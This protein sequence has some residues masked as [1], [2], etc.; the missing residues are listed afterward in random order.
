[1]LLG[2][3]FIMT[4]CL[5]AG[6]QPDAGDPG[7]RRLDQLAADRVFASLPAGAVAAGPLAEI[8][9]RYRTPAFQPPGWDGPAV[10]LTFTSSRSPASVFSFFQAR[11]ASAGWSPANRNALGYPQTWTKTYPD[12]VRG[13][14]SL[15]QTVRVPEGGSA[16][17]VLNASCPPAVTT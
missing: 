7:N 16:T 15:I 8:P 2:L 13:D 11:A 5:R 1:V 6:S 10:S 14:L 3:A 17:F 12:G 4:A 9:A